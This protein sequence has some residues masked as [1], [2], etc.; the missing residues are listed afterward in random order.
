MNDEIKLFCEQN[1]VTLLTVSPWFN[2]G[3]EEI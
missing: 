1:Q 3:F 2:V